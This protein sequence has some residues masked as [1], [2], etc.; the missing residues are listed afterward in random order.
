MKTVG[1]SV[2]FIWL[3][4]LV[5]TAQQIVPTVIGA[6]GNYRKTGS[7]S[8]EWTLGEWMVETVGN[9]NHKITQGFHQT[10]LTV[11]STSNPTLSGMGVYPNP[12]SATLKIDNRSEGS[13]QIHLMD[14]LGQ[15]IESKALPVGLHDLDFQALP[16]GFYLLEATNGNA[17][18]TLTIEKIRSN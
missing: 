11:V 18:Q 6:A 16:D 3:F 17:R 15:C 4:T 13:I 2:I 7:V 1:C 5:A 9:P 10:N 14:L 12:F 8:L